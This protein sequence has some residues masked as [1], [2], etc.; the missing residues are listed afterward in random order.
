MFI[1]NLIHDIVYRTVY[2]VYVLWSFDLLV[3]NLL[4]MNGHDEGYYKNESWGLY[5]ISTFLLLSM[6]DF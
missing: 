4:I 3:S 5:S 1:Q 6:V 2:H